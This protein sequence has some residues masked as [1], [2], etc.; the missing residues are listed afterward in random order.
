MSM[1][2]ADM[3]RPQPDMDDEGF[4]ASCAE[5]RLC[6]QGCADCGALRHPPTP[7][8]WHC[9]SVKVEWIEAPVDARLYTYNVVHHASHP[10][11]TQAVPYIGA[12]VEF[13]ALPGVRLVTNIVDADPADISIGMPVR[14]VWDDIGEGMNVYRFAPK[15]D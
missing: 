10:A 12:V 11:V 14:L 5:S 13:P 7:I 9:H 4:W 2:P 1:F 15:R 6:F 3:P 8:C